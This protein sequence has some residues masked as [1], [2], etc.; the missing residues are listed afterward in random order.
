[1]TDDINTSFLD[2]PE[3][4]LESVEE[5][6]DEN[7]VIDE[8]D[9]FDLSGDDVTV[10]NELESAPE[11]SGELVGETD[12]VPTSS[13]D[14]GDNAYSIYGSDVPITSISR[15]ADDNLDLLSAGETAGDLMMTWYIQ[16]LLMVLLIIYCV[17]L[18]SWTAWQYLMANYLM[19]GMRPSPCLA[20]LIGLVVSLVTLSFTFTLWVVLPGF[21]LPYVTA[22]TVTVAFILRPVLTIS[23]PVRILMAILWLLRNRDFLPESPIHHM[24]FSRFLRLLVFIF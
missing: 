8:T 20:L 24:S 4:A 18:T 2:N 19:L 3:K 11:T 21:S 17:L 13:G 16:L 5:S 15:A 6:I 22:D 23:I 1:M 12:S 9:E 7:K 10:S 14:F